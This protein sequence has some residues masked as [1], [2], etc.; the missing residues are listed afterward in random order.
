MLESAPFLGLKMGKIWK[1]PPSLG[2]VNHRFPSFPPCFLDVSGYKWWHVKGHVQWSQG[3]VILK[4]AIKESF[5]FRNTSS[6]KADP[7]AEQQ[8]QGQ[9]R[10][11]TE[12]A[13]KASRSFKR[14]NADFR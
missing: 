10:I 3:T 13:I 1:N 2:M 9:E 5:D 7:Q 12:N 8:T 14:W 4:P 6:A 11:H